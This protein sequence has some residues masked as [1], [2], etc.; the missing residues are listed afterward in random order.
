M[1]TENIIFTGVAIY[2]LGMLGVGFYASKKSQTVTD[3]MVA[4]RGLSLPILSMTV[5]AT[6]FGGAM[7]LGGAG[8]AF[9]GGMLGVIADPWGGALAL[10]LVGLF[11]ARL[12]RKLK[13][14]TVTDFMEQRFGKTAG[15]AITITTIVSNTMWVAG[16]LVA[17]GTIFDSLTNIP[18]ETGII[19]GA[20]IVFAYTML[21][22]MWAVA[23][24][25][26]VQ[27]TIIIIGLIILLAVVLID[28]GGWGAVS[29]QLPSGT[30]SMLPPENTAE[31]W[32]NYLRAWT[33]IGLVDITAQTLFQRASAAKT[34]D[35]ARRAFLI[36]GIGYLTFGMI[37]VFLGIIG[38][39]TMPELANSEFVIPEMAKAHLHP[40]AI[41]IFVGAMLAAI[42]SSADSALLAASSILAKNVLPAIKRDPSPRLSL[43]VVRLGIPLV[44][45]V[46]ILIALRIQVVFDLMVD[47]NILGLAAIIV[48]FILGA[49][50]RKANRTGALAGIAAGLVTWLATLQLWPALPADFMGLGASLLVM[51]VVVPLTQRFDPPKPLLDSDG[52]PVEV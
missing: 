35:I 10:V 9:D 43:L 15:V 16:M 12:F 41:A 38:S 14:I 27:M 1:S 29:R 13:I 18:I 32:L 37:P 20:V 34:A 46:A 24:T 31:Q 47:A 5:L 17:F 3:F 23:L 25:D 50:W 21:G 11:F 26:F 2:M 30:F 33:I 6:W 44:G 51:L 48:P 45:G 22:G 7:M 49:Y 19:I 40:V 42:M 8:A 4:G 36:G 39:V 52:N 28:V